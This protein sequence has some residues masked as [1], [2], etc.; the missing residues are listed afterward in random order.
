MLTAAT[1]APTS[2]PW[3]PAV[4][5]YA[6]RRAEQRA[7]ML[8][9]R[10]AGLE[11]EALLR[12]MVTEIFPGRIAVVSSFGA[13]SVVLLALLARIDPG[14]PV[15]FLDSLK[16]FPET[17]AYRDA[18]RDRLGLSDLRVVTPEPAALAAAD[19]A[20]DLWAR[21]PD[22]CCQLRKVLPLDRALVGFDAW[23]SGRKRFQ[24]GERVQMEVFEA[25]DGRI[26]INPLARWSAARIAEAFRSEN[27]PPHPLIAGGYRS[28]GCAPCTRQTAAEEASRAGRWAG[29]G[30]TECG[31]HKAKWA[32]EATP[33]LLT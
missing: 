12:T 33:G 26:K 7:Q 30:K 24:G 11:G 27:L 5:D 31:I 1:T 14:V 17:I 4:D 9:L 16:H 32:K 21:N 3:V 6:R 13:E 20:G 15:I 19:P 25:S 23:I 10:Y 28:I 2:T 29:S 22:L 8:R 18:L